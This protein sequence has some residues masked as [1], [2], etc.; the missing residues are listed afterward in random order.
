[1]EL[2]RWKDMCLCR[3]SSCKINALCAR[4]LWGIGNAMDSSDSEA[5]K[6]DLCGGGASFTV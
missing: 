2:I 4:V 6:V 3:Q 1:M 5:G